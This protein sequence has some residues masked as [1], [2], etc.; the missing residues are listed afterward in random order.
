MRKAHDSVGYPM[1]VQ[2]PALYNLARHSGLR[3]GI[4]HY[5]SAR[6]K[7]GCFYLRIV[8]TQKNK[9]VY[10][11]TSLSQ[12]F[13]FQGIFMPYRIGILLKVQKGFNAAALLEQGIRLEPCLDGKFIGS[14]FLTEESGRLLY[15]EI[16]KLDKIQKMLVYQKSDFVLHADWNFPYDEQ[17]IGYL[18]LKR[19]TWALPCHKLFF[20]PTW[21][22]VANEM[23]KYKTEKAVQKRIDSKMFALLENK[24]PGGGWCMSALDEDEAWKIYAALKH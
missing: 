4:P 5:K 24:H 8:I 18:Y 21:Q 15:E 12:I 17:F 14:E 2:A 9:N 19:P 22:H 7:A 10:S 1:R 11:F 13:I 16:L 3:A 20:A 6:F 23:D